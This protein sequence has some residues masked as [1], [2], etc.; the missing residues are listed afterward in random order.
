MPEQSKNDFPIGLLLLL[1]IGAFVILRAP[2][3]A[4]GKSSLG[5][6]TAK[7]MPAMRANYK[8]ICL[9]AATLIEAKQLA[10][11]EALLKW[12]APK[13]E[14]AREFAF[15]GFY[16]QLNESIPVEFDGKEAEVAATL[17]TIAGAW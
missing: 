11:E 13:T 14:A 12:L 3:A 7:V 17:R 16:K 10:N 5:S 2:D 8:A 9:E 4:D 15:A 1:A 6:E